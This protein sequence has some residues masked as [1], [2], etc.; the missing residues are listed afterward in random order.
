MNAIRYTSRHRQ[1]GTAVVETIV[2]A[3]VLLF[4]VLIGAEITNAFVDHNTLTKSARYAVRY[5]AENALEGTTSVV[6]LDAN[7][8]YSW[9]WV[10][11]N[12]Y[13]LVEFFYNGLGQ[14][15]Y[16]KAIVDPAVL[17][18]LARG[19]L[20]TLGKAYLSG[21]IQLETHPLVNIYLT[22]INNLEDPS[23]IIQPKMVW[24]IKQYLQLNAGA[25]I[26]YGGGG[27]EYGGVYMESYDFCQVPADS[28]YCILTYFF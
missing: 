14:D 2:A 12:M 11:K 28:I 18:R 16:V 6:S 9:T 19:E 17:E 20:F 13:G 8:D 24:D 22:L 1:Q 4:L 21:L 23:G 5:L 3:P 10:G 7:L 26:Y 25:T 27:T 15:E